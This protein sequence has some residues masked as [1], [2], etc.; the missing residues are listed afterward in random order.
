VKTEPRAGRPR[1][2]DTTNSVGAR[3]IRASAI[4][5][6]LRPRILEALQQDLIARLPE[7]AVADVFRWRLK[8]ADP[9]ASPSPQSPVPSP[10]S[11]A[12]LRYTSAARP[13]VALPR[14][15]LLFPE[16]E[17]CLCGLAI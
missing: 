4:K 2:N 12:P 7:V 9:A 6:E 10:E 1:A 8:D 11:P 15:S 13:A 17:I 14:L 16:P 3:T 5:Q